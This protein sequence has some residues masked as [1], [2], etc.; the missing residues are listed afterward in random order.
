[1]NGDARQLKQG[2]TT[3]NRS[4]WTTHSVKRANNLTKIAAM[5]HYYQNQNCKT[6]PTDQRAVIP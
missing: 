6:K 4:K 1:M 5:D 2:R 3:H